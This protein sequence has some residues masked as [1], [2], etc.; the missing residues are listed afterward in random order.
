MESNNLERRLKEINESVKKRPKEDGRLRRKLKK[1]GIIS[2]FSAV[3]IGIPFYYLFHDFL[4][5]RQHYPER[6]VLFRSSNVLY[7]AG[8]SENK[9][10]TADQS[11]E[12]EVYEGGILEESKVGTYLFRTVREIRE[13]IEYFNMDDSQKI[14]IASATKKSERVQAGLR[15]RGSLNYREQFAE[16]I[17][18]EGSKAPKKYFVYKFSPERGSRE[19]EVTVLE[20]EEGKREIDNIL[21]ELRTFPHG[22]TFGKKFRDGT[23]LENYNGS[24]KQEEEFLEGIKLLNS[25]ETVDRKK[26]EKIIEGLIS[27]E[28]KMAKGPVYFS[29]EDGIIDW[30]PQES[31]IYLA[32]KP[33]YLKREWYEWVGFGRNDHNFLRIENYWDL[34]PGRYPFLDNFKI[35]DKYNNGGY[36][37]KDKFGDIAKINIEDFFLFYGR[38]VLYSYYLDLNGDGKI[39]KDEIIGSVLCRTAHDENPNLESLSGKNRPKSDVTFTNNYSFMAPDQNRELGLKYFEL[40]S[41]IESMIPDQI[42]RGFGKHSFLGFIN[43]QRSDMMLYRD[44]SIGNM[45]RSL[46]EEATFVAKYD[47]IRVLNASR[48]PY[49]EELA[50]KY[51]IAEDFIGQYQSSELL[52]ERSEIGPLLPALGI[53]GLLGT[54]LVLAYRTHKKRRKEDKEMLLSQITK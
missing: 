19:I 37:I 23:F 6:N 27:S 26:R 16:I 30:L 54:S 2:L 39:S 52:K 48:R 29:F 45:S 7:V 12:S 24:E 31:S 20:H 8:S 49:A 17:L 4:T 28:R 25:T 35:F 5:K 46:T 34:F 41:Y 32:E 15:L 22:W 11:S 14:R 50:R 43:E 40:C 1:A 38:D 10:F 33:S 3:L 51:G 47:I 18:G 42:H 9:D 13:D 44:L 53:G 21:T 36:V